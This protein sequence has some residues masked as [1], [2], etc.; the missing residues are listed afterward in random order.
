MAEMNL[1]FVAEARAVQTG[2]ILLDQGDGVTLLGSSQSSTDALKARPQDHDL[3]PISQSS[4]RAL[5]HDS[6]ACD[7][8]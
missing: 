2:V 1:S 4:P 7:T 5:A 8:H 3:I 6:A